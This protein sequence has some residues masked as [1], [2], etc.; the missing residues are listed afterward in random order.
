MGHNLSRSPRA[1]VLLVGAL[2]F[3]ACSGSVNFSFGG[4]SPAEAAVELIEG[5]AMAQRLGIDLLTNVVC[6][7]P[8][9]TEV[10]TVFSCTADSAGNAVAFEVEL[11]AEDRIFAAPSNVVEARRLTDYATSAVQALNDSNGFTLP[12]DAIDCGDASIVL[13]ADSQM[14]C[15]L[16]DPDNGTLYDAV[17]T[18]SDTDSGAF[19]VEI[20]DAAE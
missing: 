16:T 18:V 9:D 10:G 5:A 7:D 8:P 2:V 11:E 20:V 14:I 15:T 1:A 12:E 19:D 13:D 4:Q 6:T 17:L 3:S